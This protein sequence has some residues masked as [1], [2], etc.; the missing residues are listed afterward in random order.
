MTLFS[1]LIVPSTADLG[2]NCSIQATCKSVIDYVS[3]NKTTLAHI[4]T[5][6]GVANFYDLLGANS[7]TV[8][9][10]SNYIV[11]AKAT[12]KIPFPCNCSNGTGISNRV[13]YYKVQLGDGLDHIARN[14][15]SELVTYQQIAQVNNISDPNVIQTGQELWIPLPCSCV[16]VGGA[17][18]VHYGHVVTK[19][20]TVEQIAEEYG[21]DQNTL[22]K[23]NGMADANALIAG[24]VID[25][26]LKV[27]SSS[28][29]KSSEDYPMLVPNGT[30]ALTAYN[31]VQ[32]SCQSSYH[33]YTLQCKPSGVEPTNVTQCPSMTCQD[34]SLIGNTTSTCSTCAY[35]G[36]LKT[37][38][39]TT[40][41]NHTCSG[42]YAP[43]RMGS[44]GSSWR[45]LLITIHLGL[46]CFG[47]LS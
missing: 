26:P 43:A 33:N 11:E 42:N 17:Q 46:L 32:C 6:F 2:F 36:Y 24:Q 47:L 44:Q 19:G 16:E 15:Y 9:T 18:V 23:L 40:L 38:I 4:S 27:C 34:G 5:L 7:L 41:D 12:I 39:F 29:N 13:P 22:L 20:S 21:T 3:P 1:A 37:N 31:C 10:K 30:Y 28:V 45:I 14:V 25:V 35:A 8:S